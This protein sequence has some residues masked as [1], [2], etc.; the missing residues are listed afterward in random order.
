MRERFDASV[1]RHLADSPCDVDSASASLSR[2]T[3]CVTDAARET[4]PVKRSQLVRKREVS[5]RTKL[6]FEE[7]RRNVHKM[8]DRERHEASRAITVSSRNDFRHYDME[9]AGNLRIVSK[10]KRILAHKDCRTSCNPSKGAGGRPITTTTQLLSEWE[11]FLGTKFKRPAADADR[12][13]ESAAAEEDELGYDDLR[14]CLKALRSGKATGWDDVPVEAYRG[15]VHATSELFR[16]CR[17]RSG[18]LQNWC[19]AYSLCC[20]RRAHETTWQTTER[21]A[22]SA[23]RTSCS[24]PSWRG[25]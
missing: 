25:D 6:L 23:I 7:R 24:R 12:N 3:K 5:Q 21:F 14:D 8:N 16:I 9:A 11:K 10:L 17:T 18:S 15:S 13:L 1:A 22:S 4:L 20:T 2:L 19:E